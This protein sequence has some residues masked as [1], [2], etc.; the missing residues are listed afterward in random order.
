MATSNAFDSSRVAEGVGIENKHEPSADAVGSQ[1]RTPQIAV[2]A[3]VNEAN[4]ATYSSTKRRITSQ[5]NVGLQEGYGSPAH[6]IADVFF[7]DNGPEINIPVYLYPLYVSGDAA[8]GDITPSITTLTKTG[9]YQAKI[10]G[11]KSDPWSVVVGDT[12]ATIIDKMVTAIN[13]VAKMPVIA[14]DGTTTCNLTAKW[15]GESGNNIQASIIAP[16][17][18]EVTYGLTQ[19]TGGTGTPDITAALA[20]IG[21]AWD[22]HIVNALDYTDSDELDEYEAFGES[23]RAPEVHKYL[24]VYTGTNEA[25]RA[26]VTAVTDARKSDRTNVIVPVP[27]SPDLPCVIAADAVREIATMDAAD[28]SHDYVNLKLRN[29]TPGTDAQEWDSDER[30]IAVTSGCSTTKWQDGS[31]LI[32]DIVTCYHPTGEVEP[33]FRYVV[34]IAKRST[35]VH[36]AHL[37]ISQLQGRPVVAD[38]DSPENPNAI[39]CKTIKGMLDGMSDKL[40]SKLTVITNP[41]FAK[42]KS[43]VSIS[44]VNSKRVNIEY[45]Y[46]LSGNANVIA[47]TCKSQFYYGG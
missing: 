26:T 22:T 46:Q 20:Q 15:H 28:P 25:T 37:L 7:P 10:G 5:H 32:S 42:E 1:K 11:V 6:R 31:V 19:P 12:V 23:R 16:D 8:A 44:D 45:I 33:G 40:S 43:S 2:F 21:T 27:G 29:V 17:D 35:V 4:S 13:A 14:A 47:M 34:D 36:N 38:S 30:Q 18:A 41:A 39:K 9:K 3:Q 24:T